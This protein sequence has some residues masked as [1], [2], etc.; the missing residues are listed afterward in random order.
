[1]VSGK[2]HHLVFV[3]FSKYMFLS[4][5][6]QSARNMGA[7]EEIIHLNDGE[8]WSSLETWVILN[9]VLHRN[10][11]IHGSLLVSFSSVDS[12]SC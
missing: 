1:M 5:G 8:T 9:G 7:G 3:Y 12:M 11:V 2:E 4:H 6:K 10:P